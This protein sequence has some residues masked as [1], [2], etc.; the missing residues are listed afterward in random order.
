MIL[1][2]LQPDF[3]FGE[4]VK[5]NASWW[6]NN[7]GGALTE[8]ESPLVSKAQEVFLRVFAAA[9]KKM[10]VEP[11]LVILRKQG[12][13][14]AAALKDG[15]ILLSQGALEF[16]FKGVSESGGLSRLA[17]V[18]GHE[19]AHLLKGDFW[20]IA[21]FEIVRKYGTDKKAVDEIL[22]IL[23]DTG[24]ISTTDHARKIAKNKELQAD[25]YGLLY[26]AVAGYDPKEI[27]N[28]NGKNFFREW[29]NQITGRAAY[30]DNSHPTPDMRAEF[31]YSKM[32]EV[33]QSLVL[34]DLGIRLYQLGRYND[35]LDFL[36]AFK[37]KFPCREVDNNIGLIYYQKAVNILAKNDPDR[38]YGFQLST[39][40]D[41]ETRGNSFKRE[42]GWKR[43]FD[44]NIYKA[45]EYFKSACQKDVLYIPARIN[46]SSARIMQQD[47]SGALSI[48][49][50]AL[51]IKKDECQALNNKAAALYLFG[52]SNK[53]DM[54][55]QAGEILQSLIQNQPGFSHAFYNMGII[56]SDQGKK[57]E[58]DK[59][60]KQYLELEPSGIP[61]DAVRKS[62]GIPPV[63]N[64]GS[65]SVAGS[66]L[67]SLPVKPGP[68]D[69]SIDRKLSGYASHN[70]DQKGIFGS[71]YVKNNFRVLILEDI[72][73][74]VEKFFNNGK[75][76]S[77]INAEYGRPGRIIDGF[78]SIKTLV[79]E[80]AAMDIK[81]NR[82]VR[83]SITY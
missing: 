59:I 28:E 73:M 62:M 83:M 17:F 25:S 32:E 82:L 34:F 18:I 74:L 57:A 4:S 33:R 50:Q 41:I 46:L 67:S 11:R 42:P 8:E 58:S 47:Y 72:V 54:S 68:C 19:M 15:T 23:V 65:S 51:N 79:Y 22:D 21:A 6:V 56:L 24:D 81:N 27:V 61:A 75:H 26:A 63:K 80:N 30:T 3:S 78:S 29:V 5:D 7:Y 1:L 36:T 45:A 13:P 60:R 76:I 69:H 12:E 48:L 77:E 9:D 38:L 49:D 31:L 37:E 40:L 44:R 14:W 43:D 10:N 55:L 53:A 35:A 64:A 66:L 2:L 16:C 52:K 70:I 20:H 39:V 71:Y